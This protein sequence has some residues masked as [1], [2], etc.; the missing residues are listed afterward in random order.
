MT[1]TSNDL[2]PWKPTR[3][4]HPPS[5]DNLL[6]ELEQEV[7]GLPRSPQAY[8]LNVRYNIQEV[9]KLLQ[10]WGLSWPIVAAGY[11][12]SYEDHLFQKRPINDLLQIQEHKREALNYMHHIE[13][14]DL[15]T[16]LNPP[17]KD[18]GGLLIALA[19]YIVAL[20]KHAQKRGEGQPYQSED[21]TQIGVVG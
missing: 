2:S 4:M 13:D 12:L 14:D 5:W 20:K 10:S 17:Y 21:I 18:L 9:G 6:Y 15:F 8:V 19:V 11:L 3:A 16:L 7:R 1:Q